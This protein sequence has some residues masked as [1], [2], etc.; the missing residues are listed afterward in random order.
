MD[1][2]VSVVAGINVSSPSPNSFSLVPGLTTATNTTM[3]PS[4]IITLIPLSNTQ[5]VINLKL[6]NNNYLFWHMQ[7]KSYLI[8]Q[9]VFSFVDSSTPC[10]LRTICPVRPL[11][12]LLPSILAPAKHF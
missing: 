12:S 5:Q 1:Q 11:L 8:G 7:M 9:G 6:N 3:T 10:P 4:A 2:L